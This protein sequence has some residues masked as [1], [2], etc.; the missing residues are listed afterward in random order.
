MKNKIIVLLLM[1]FSI[2]NT[3]AQADS[4]NIRKWTKNHFIG[5]E[6]LG[7]LIFY[8]VFYEFKLTKYKNNFGVGYGTNFY[9]T[10][11][12]PVYGNAFFINYSYGNKHS[13][14]IEVAQSV[15]FQSEGLNDN[16]KG[17]FWEKPEVFAK[18]NSFSFGYLF[19]KKRFSI[20][21]NGVLL[22]AYGYKV[23]YSPIDT[24]LIKYTELRK[25]FGFGIKYKL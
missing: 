7:K 6:G 5:I 1:V 2:F 9:K 23:S 21:I 25:S 15:N 16:F 18:F 20:F 4:L 12:T 8:S 14:T 22:Y 10:H 19:N 17:N 11:I 24:N 3:N 13:L